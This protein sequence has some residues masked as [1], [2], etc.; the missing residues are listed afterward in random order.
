MV[1]EVG[2][3]LLFNLWVASVINKMILWL[4][5][6]VPWLL[7]INLVMH[8]SDQLMVLESVAW[9]KESWRSV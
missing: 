5:M 8:G 6:L 1:A 4:F 3:N 2:S 9:I 7:F